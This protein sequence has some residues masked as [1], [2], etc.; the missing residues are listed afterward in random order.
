MIETLKVAALV[1][2]VSPF[3]IVG[4]GVLLGLVLGISQT[5]LGVVFGMVMAFQGLDPEGDE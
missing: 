2:M 5:L 3:I 1:A 4:A